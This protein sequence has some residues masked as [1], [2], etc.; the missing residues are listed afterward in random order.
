MGITFAT[1]E[2]H[3]KEL[4]NNNGPFPKDPN[5]YYDEHLETT[6]ATIIKSKVY[7]PA[8]KTTITKRSMTPQ[9]HRAERER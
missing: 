2:N 9:P 5:G 8:S 3:D 4:P 1:A 6:G 7:F